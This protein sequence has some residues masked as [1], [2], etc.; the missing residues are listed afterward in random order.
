MLRSLK[1]TRPTLPHSQ[2][3]AV[4]PG[5]QG[6]PVTIGPTAFANASDPAVA[7]AEP[8]ASRV[9]RKPRG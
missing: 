2:S 7:G 4:M 6:A 3:R 5:A 1:W 8:R 9:P